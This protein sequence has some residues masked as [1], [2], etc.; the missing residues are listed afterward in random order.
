MKFKDC[1]DFVQQI[2]HYGKHGYVK[3]DSKY[4][5]FTQV[6]SMKMVHKTTGDVE[7]FILYPDDESYDRDYKNDAFVR[8]IYIPKD[9]NTEV[10]KI[11]PKTDRRSREHRSPKYNKEE[12]QDSSEIV[13]TPKPKPY[14][15]PRSTDEV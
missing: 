9:Y 14:S 13:D 12:T 7:M 8:K 1:A 15:K 10:R 4:N 3:K 5:P 11:E 6:N 2:N